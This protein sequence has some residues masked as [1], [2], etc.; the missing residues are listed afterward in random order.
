MTAPGLLA[1]HVGIVVRD[2]D[3]TMKQYSAM[4]DIGRW[5]RSRG[6]FNGI[7]MAYGLGPGQSIELFQVTGPGDSHI[8]QFSSQ[9]GE[10]VNHIGVW[11]EDVPAAARKAV[12]A[13]AELLSITADADGNATAQLLPSKDVTAGHFAN[14]GIATFVNPSGG[15]LIEYVGRA[16]EQFMRDWFKE[17]YDHVVMPSPWSHQS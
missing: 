15:V 2:L 10:G 17:N 16:G 14:L 11:A 6:R 5:H 3:Q 8:H 9:H 7:E 12:D 4:F 1:F 13:G